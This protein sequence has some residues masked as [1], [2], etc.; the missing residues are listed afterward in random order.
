MFASNVIEKF[1]W[2]N[3]EVKDL[4]NEER[5]I[6]L[7]KTRLLYFTIWTWG[8]VKCQSYV[9]PKKKVINPPPANKIKR[10]SRW[11]QAITFQHI[12]GFPNWIWGHTT[13]IPH[14]LRSEI[15]QPMSLQ[16]LIINSYWLYRLLNQQVIKR[17]WWIFSLKDH[18]LFGIAANYECIPFYP[19]PRTTGLNA[20]PRHNSWLA[21]LR[22][23]VCVC[24]CMKECVLMCVWEGRLSQ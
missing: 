24:V 16:S 10:I 20:W 3:F 4:R 6:V 2:A 8:Y 11:C 19:L 1:E 23:C 5:F 12:S 13:S 15:R 14:I 18:S 22:P 17:W 7:L 21:A 9:N